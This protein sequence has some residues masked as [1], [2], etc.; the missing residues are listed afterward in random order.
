MQYEVTFRAYVNVH[1]TVDADNEKQAIHRAK[2][3]IQDQINREYPNLPHAVDNHQDNLHI[4][5]EPSDVEITG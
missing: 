4:E 3:G 2:F 5:L 1:V